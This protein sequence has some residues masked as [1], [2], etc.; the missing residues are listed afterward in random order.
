MNQGDTVGVTVENSPAG[1]LT[2][3]DF[4]KQRQYGTYDTGVYYTGLGGK[5]Y[6]YSSVFMHVYHR[7]LCRA[8]HVG[9]SR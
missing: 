5:P 7:N 9:P 1:G 2:V 6:S 4:G 3:N 8:R